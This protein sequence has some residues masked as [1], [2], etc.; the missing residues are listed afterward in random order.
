MRYG[1]V[2][3]R[4]E[5]PVG[6]TLD[7]G[8]RLD[9]ACACGTLELFPN[10]RVELGLQA[11]VSTSK[12]L[13]LK[14]SHPCIPPGTSTNLVVVGLAQ[15]RVVGFSMSIFSIGQIGLPVL[16]AG[17]IYIMT[18]APRFLPDR[19]S[20]T[21]TLQR[22]REYIT[23]MFVR[24]GDDPEGSGALDG[25]TISSAGLRSLPGLYL[26]RIERENHTVVT[27]PGP[28]DILKGGDKL[29]FAGVVDS[30][31]SLRQIRGLRLAENEV[32]QGRIRIT[33]AARTSI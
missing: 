23:V 17:L 11:P 15:Q 24:K 25:K 22:P 32:G 18:M 21:A 20:V 26:V 10:G 13:D 6:E 7:D 12:C 30:V 19:G 31:L 1:Q 9:G 3:A 28:D 8:K 5:C 33:S 14:L 2:Q 29:F 4:K 16:V 27:A